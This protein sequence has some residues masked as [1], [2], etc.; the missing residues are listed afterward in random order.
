MS[1]SDLTGKAVLVAGASSGMGRATALAAAEAGA[2]VALFARRADELALTE[3]AVRAAGRKAVSVAGDATDARAVKQAVDAAVDTFGRLDVLVNSVGT[4]IR[5]RALTELTAEGWNELLHVNIN[6]AFVLTQ[7]VLPVFRR[8][9]EGLLIH[10]SSSAAKRPDASGAGYQVGKA[11][12]AALAHATMEE[13]RANGIRVT[14][15]YPGFTDTALVLKRPTPPTAEMLAKALWP[16]DIAQM[17]VA[18]MGLPPR[19]HVPELLLYP[20]QS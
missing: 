15:I 5:E 11:G 9:G 14:V 13:E 20:T 1:G 19:A 3:A 8:A 18:V 10:Y 12:V 7:A 4:N 2:D 17:C 6:S 16:E